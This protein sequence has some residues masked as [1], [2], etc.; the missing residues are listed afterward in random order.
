MSYFVSINSEV[1]LFIECKCRIVV[2]INFAFVKD[3]APSTFFRKPILDANPLRHLLAAFFHSLAVS[4][5]AWFSCS[6]F[7]MR[8]WSVIVLV[9][10]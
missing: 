2:G 7:S 10:F 4:R 6:R 3:Y 1:E 5:S 9:P 8:S